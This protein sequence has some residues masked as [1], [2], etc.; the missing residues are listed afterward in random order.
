V[1]KLFKE[2]KQP[3]KIEEKMKKIK[4]DARE[5]MVLHRGSL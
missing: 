1:K 2:N 3:E 4:N 5:F